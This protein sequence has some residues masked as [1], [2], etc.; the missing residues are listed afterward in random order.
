MDAPTGLLFSRDHEWVRIGG[1][2]ARVGLT[3]QAQDALGD[4]VYVDLPDVG[5]RV[6]AGERTGE[7]ESMK[8]VSEVYA[9][10]TGIVSRVNAALESDPG[11][12]NR[13]PYGEGWLY[14]LTDFDSSAA[15]SL[16]DTESYNALGA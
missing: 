12:V 11:L 2:I 1:G 7:I 13:D 3:D 15:D 10:L 6:I 14:E 5:I 16:L 4:A 8:S 9:P